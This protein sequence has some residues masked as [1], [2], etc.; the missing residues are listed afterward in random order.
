MDDPL[1][2][3]IIP[4]YRAERFLDECL[5]SVAGQDYP[6]LEI[7]LVDDGSP[8]SCPEMCDRYAETCGRVKTIHKKNEGPGPA[9]NTGLEAAAGKYVAFVDSD[10][11][12]DGAGVIGRLVERAEKKQADIIV[13]SFRRW[14]GRQP[15]GVEHHRLREG[16]YTETADF[17]FRGLI[18]SDH[19]IS[20]CGKLYRRAFLA[21]NGLTF[22]AHPFREDHFFNMACCACR[23][24]YAFIDESVYLRRSN[25]D[26]LSHRYWN[27]YASAYAAV[28]SDF[29][30]FLSERGM[31][32]EYGDLIAYYLCFG[33]FLLAKQE[34]AYKGMAKTVRALSAYGKHPLVRKTA[35][36]LARGRYIGRIEQKVWRIMIWGASLLCSL[37][38]Y[39][40][41]AAGIWALQKIG[42]DKRL[43]GRPNEP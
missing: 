43:T 11:C 17:R 38:A 3:V 29:E 40:L 18:L 6:A 32:E 22:R 30:G 2:S 25:G 23:P 8:D 9:R 33:L 39:F 15:G 27:D 42:A 37:H 35:R 4:V 13:G 41:L 10:D 5:N 21:D 28:A 24:R 26:S 31:A 36:E 16:A 12:L 34:L 7:I 19:M 20:A 14:D 1:V